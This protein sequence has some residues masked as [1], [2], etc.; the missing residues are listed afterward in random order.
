MQRILQSDAP[1]NVDL[2]DTWFTP[3]L[4]E[5]ISKTPGHDPRFAPEN[6]NQM[7]ASPQSKQNIQ[8]I[9][10]IKGEPASEVQEYPASE[11]VIN[12]STLKKVSF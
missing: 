11:G 8:E 9:P 7:I 2:K 10:T 6:N 12:I 4:E 3:Y 5:D 1:E